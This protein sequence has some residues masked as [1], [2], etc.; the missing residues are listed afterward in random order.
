MQK[1]C[2]C[3][4]IAVC[5][6]ISLPARS[7]AQEHVTGSEVMPSGQ[8]SSVAHEYRPR[9]GRTRAGAAIY[10]G[11][12]YRPR[13]WC[14]FYARFNFASHD[15][16]RAFN[17]ARNWVRFGRPVSG[18]APGVIGVQRHHVFKVISVIGPGVVMAISGNDGHAVRTRPRS[19]RGVIAWRIE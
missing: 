15:P 13:A 6:M 10:R 16:G 19:T 2:I 5:V 11:Y 8:I 14:G 4:A 3:A 18:P 9:H 7:A 17:L 1:P 12:D